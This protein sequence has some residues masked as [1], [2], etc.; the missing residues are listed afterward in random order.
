MPK[1]NNTETT[2]QAIQ[3]AVAE[4]IKKIQHYELILVTLKSKRAEMGQSGED[5]INHFRY[6]IQKLQKEIQ[7]L[8]SVLR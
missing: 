5:C 8:E 7:L 6:F 4:R 2:E 1:S 3:I